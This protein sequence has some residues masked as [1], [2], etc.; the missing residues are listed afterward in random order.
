MQMD[1]NMNVFN[2]MTSFATL[3]A[4]PGV[5]AGGTSNARGNQAGTGNPTSLFTVTG[6]VLVQI[7][8]VGITTLTGASAT[9]SF[10]VTGNTGLLIASTTATSIAATDVWLSNAPAIGFAYSS[11][12]TFILPYSQN[13]IETVGTANITGGNLYYVCLW[14]PLSSGSTVVSNF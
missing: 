8:G 5:F 6:N 14:R 9:L 3:T 4:K 11:L 7:Y 1:N 10:G 13:I 12:G 2:T